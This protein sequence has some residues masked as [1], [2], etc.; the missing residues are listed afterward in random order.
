MA[1]LIITIQNGPK[2]DKFTEGFLKYRPIPL[3]ENGDPKYALLQ[4]VKLCTVQY[5]R[6]DC[7]NGLHLIANQSVVVEPDLIE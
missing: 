4:W 6:G 1:Q 2:L 5:L 7:I 3:D